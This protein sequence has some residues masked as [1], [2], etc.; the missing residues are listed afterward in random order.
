MIGWNDFLLLNV[1][2]PHP[3]ILMLVDSPFT[4]S[5]RLMT[6]IEMLFRLCGK[7]VS[8]G[9]SWSDSLGFV[10]HELLRI[11]SM[12]LGD[13]NRL[14]EQWYDWMSSD[15]IRWAVIWLDEQWYDWMSSDMIGWVVIWWDERT[16]YLY[17]VYPTSI[18]SD[19]DGFSTCKS[20][21][22]TRWFFF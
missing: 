15:M 13:L 19:A 16:F 20:W 17:T 9:C 12:F 11:D 1:F 3:F 6:K 8:R 7:K 21:L 2:P 14:D 10:N 4:K 5:N 22:L 18:H